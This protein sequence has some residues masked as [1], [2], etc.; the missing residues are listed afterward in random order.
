MCLTLKIDRWN[1]HHYWKIDEQQRVKS[2]RISVAAQPHT[3]ARRT[4]NSMRWTA[5][6]TCSSDNVN[7]LISTGSNYSTNELFKLSVSSRTDSIK[8]A[9]RNCSDLIH[10]LSSACKYNVVATRY[11]STMFVALNL[12]YFKMHTTTVCMCWTSFCKIAPVFC[13]TKQIF[14]FEF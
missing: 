14:F 13:A 6:T 11:H 3:S 1:L 10:F 7:I 8:A 12:I 4:E 2:E 9:Q 5:F